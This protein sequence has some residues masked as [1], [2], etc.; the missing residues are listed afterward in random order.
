MYW[1]D[2]PANITQPHL[3]YLLKAKNPEGQILSCIAEYS[4]AA[5]LKKSLNHILELGL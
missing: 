1:S 3:H 5:I 2:L 4:M